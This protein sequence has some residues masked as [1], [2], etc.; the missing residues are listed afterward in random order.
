MKPIL[1]KWQIV[2]KYGRDWR[3]SERGW[4]RLEF[5]IL[6]LHYIPEDAG[7]MIDPSMYKGFLKHVYIWFPIDFDKY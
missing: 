5:G 1:N 6:N 4:K 2:F 7:R 3:T